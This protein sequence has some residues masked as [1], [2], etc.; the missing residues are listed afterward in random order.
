MSKLHEILRPF[1]LR[2]VKADVLKGVLPPKKEIV[3]YA[4]MTPLQ[5]TYEALILQHQLKDTLQSSGIP[6]TGKE[7]SEN[8]MLMNQRKNAN[9]PFLFGEP[10]TPTGEFVRSRRPA[11]LRCL[12]FIQTT[13][14]HLTMKW[15]V[16]FSILR[17]FGPTAMLRAGG[18]GEPE[19]AD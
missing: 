2:R 4:A 19:D 17:P 6:C 15:V 7:V 12:H 3:V 5:K 9:H 16:S 10:T 1:L 13:R 11:A 18:R 14:V 8:N